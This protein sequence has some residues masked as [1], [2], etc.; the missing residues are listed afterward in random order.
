MFLVIPYEVRT[1]TQ[2]SPWANL[3]VIGLCILVFLGFYTNYLPEN[4]VPWLIFSSE[5][6]LGLITSSLM[7]A[8]WGHLIGNMIFLWVFGNALC[9]VMNW[10]LYLALFFLLGG[11]ADLI[12]LLIDGH[13]VL[14]ASGA[15]SG[16]LGVFMALY[17]LNRV[18]SFY[19][20]VFKF[21]LWDVPGW[22]LL[23]CWFILQFLSL[24]SGPEDIAYWA[25]IGGFVSGLGLGLLL[26]KLELVDVGEYDN[27][28]LL[29]I[30]LR[31]S[32]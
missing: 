17:P 18:H 8:S 26:S 16:L 22:L 7:H 13:P 2:R 9:G 14:G 27:P 20:I 19:F 24:W 23:T 28:S 3:A 12:H 31:R 30:L 25:H 29:D 21:G 5:N 1:L 4:L 32:S 6:W 11:A 10:A 15:I